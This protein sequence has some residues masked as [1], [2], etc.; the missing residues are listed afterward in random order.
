VRYKNENLYIIVLFII[1]VLFMQFTFLADCFNRI[2][3]ESWK[4]KTP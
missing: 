3:E 2:Q 4:T 1:S